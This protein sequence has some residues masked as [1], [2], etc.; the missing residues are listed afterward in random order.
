MTKTQI[1]IGFMV[2]GMQAA[3]FGHEEITA[4]KE[5]MINKDFRKIQF[6]PDSYYNEE[7]C[8]DYKEPKK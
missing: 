3:G 6:T 2:R 7:D 4:M 1:G 8:D 5:A